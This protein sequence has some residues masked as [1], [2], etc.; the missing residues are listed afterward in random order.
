MQLRTVLKNLMKSHNIT[1]REL[2]KHTSVAEGT[3]KTWLSGAAPRSM[4]DV[5]KVARHFC[6]SFEY[7]IF[8][9]D[10][11]Q[12]TSIENLP[13]E[14]LFDGWLKVNIQR[15]VKANKPKSK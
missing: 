1:I 7:L 11:G 15:V 2:A 4:E 9:E 10:E 6:V 3:I 14:D 5:R 12:Q 13:L 8:G